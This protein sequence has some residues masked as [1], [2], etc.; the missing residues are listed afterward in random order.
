MATFSTL[1]IYLRIKTR[2]KPSGSVHWDA[3]CVSVHQCAWI[4][5]LPHW[6][7]RGISMA[8]RLLYLISDDGGADQLADR[9]PNSSQNFTMPFWATGHTHNGHFL[10]NQM[11]KCWI[12]PDCSSLG[13]WTLN[14]FTPWGHS[15]T[16]FNVEPLLAAGA[17][18]FNSL[19]SDSKR[20]ER[21]T[22]VAVLPVLSQMFPHGFQ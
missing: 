3:A 10:L 5:N 8:R 16:G 22:D 7:V 17:E 4:C 2:I 14:V 6:I 15:E 11:S 13:V 1:N 21:L 19:D 12:L 9:Y 18:R 20:P